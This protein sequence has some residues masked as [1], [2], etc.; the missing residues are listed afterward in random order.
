MAD[1]FY[2][3][4]LQ[5]LRYLMTEAHTLFR[6]ALLSIPLLLMIGTAQPTI[7]KETEP[8]PAIYGLRL[9]STTQSSSGTKKE[10]F[11]NP[12]TDVY[13]IW[14]KRIYKDTSY[15]VQMNTT[16]Y[17][18]VVGSINN[19]RYSKTFRPFTN[20]RLQRYITPKR[21]P[22]IIYATAQVFDEK[23]PDKLI[24]IVIYSRLVKVLPK[25]AN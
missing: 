8:C 6:Q 3:P 22:E 13:F 2:I 11:G 21:N 15:L 23:D 4:V 19:D 25:V 7:C 10:V 24:G 20:R 12:K 18:K 14:P 9:T 5:Q 16:G 1:G 17:G